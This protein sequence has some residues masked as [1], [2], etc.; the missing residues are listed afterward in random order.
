MWKRCGKNQTTN[1]NILLTDN[2]K[3]VSKRLEIYTDDVKCSHGSTVGQLDEN[4]LFYLRT[5]GIC[6][7]NARVLLMHAF[8]KEI[9]DKISIKAL[10]ERTERLVRKRL[11]GEI[12]S[13]NSCMQ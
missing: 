6:E 2:A 11:T 13:C 5:R 1:R 9:I 7:R 12:I 8:A 10:S 3:V 4:A